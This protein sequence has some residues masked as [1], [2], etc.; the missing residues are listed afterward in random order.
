MFKV[1]VIGCGNMPQSLLKPVGGYQFFTY[2]PS[3]TR[4]VKLASQLGGEVL[5]DYSKL[6]EMNII[7]LGCKPQNFEQV[8]NEIKDKINKDSLIISMLAGINFE[9]LKQGL[10]GH[11]KIIRIMP[12]ITAK[13][14]KGSILVYPEPNE[15][16]TLQ[17]GFLRKTSKLYPVDSEKTFDELMLITGSGPAYIYYLVRSLEKFIKNQGHDAKLYGP[18]IIETFSG[19]I[20]LMNLE[21]EL[22]STDFIERVASKGGVTEAALKFFTDS[23]FDDIVDHALKAG[24]KRSEALQDAVRK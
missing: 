14:D 16:Q 7:L 22:S 23:N 4:A 10:G 11:H 17:L 12:N 6:Q 1:A 20:D 15:E 21:P 18:A 13:V 9:S 3:R 2:T 8:S 5:D 24:V 19:A